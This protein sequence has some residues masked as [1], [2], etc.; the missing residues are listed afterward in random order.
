MESMSN[1]P[2]ALPEF[3]KGVKFG[4]GSCI[5]DILLKD[6]L[7]DVSSGLKM[8]DIAE[9]TAAEYGISRQEQVTFYKV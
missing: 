8:G 6:G 3:R 7:T 4:N 5:I 2:H 1:V 9:L